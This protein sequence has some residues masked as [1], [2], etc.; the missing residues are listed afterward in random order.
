[1]PPATM[2]APIR[3]W[4]VVRMRK[5]TP[6]FPGTQLGGEVPARR[7]AP[8]EEKRRGNA[9]PGCQGLS[10]SDSVI[11]AKDLGFVVCTSALIVVASRHRG[12][13]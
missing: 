5:M 10:A 12:L 6:S 8:G 11:H 3:A 7:G 9:H 2:V 13:G 4:M 1:M